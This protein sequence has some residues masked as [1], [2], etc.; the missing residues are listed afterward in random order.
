MPWSTARGLGPIRREKRPDSPDRCPR[1]PED[2][3]ELIAKEK[4]KSPS[5]RVRTLRR[6][7]EREKEEKEREQLQKEEVRKRWA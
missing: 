5:G 4:A 2:L 3:R 6:K 7:M 1:T